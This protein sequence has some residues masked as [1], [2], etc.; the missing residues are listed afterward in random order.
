MA[1]PRA[2]HDRNAW[3]WIEHRHVH[4]AG[5]EASRQERADGTVPDDEP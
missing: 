1:D 5:D 2:V 4:A 3:V